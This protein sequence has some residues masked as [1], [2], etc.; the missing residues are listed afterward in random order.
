MISKGEI[1]G[2]VSAAVAVVVSVWNRFGIHEI[3]VELKATKGGLKDLSV[4]WDG[5]KAE[6]DR[7]INA[8][9]QLEGRDFQH[10][11]QQKDK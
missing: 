7:G 5:L 11:Q 2:Y 10:D 3:H 6:R 9:G 4:Q 8:Q 1:A